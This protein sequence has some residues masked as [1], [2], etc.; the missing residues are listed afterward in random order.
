MALQISNDRDTMKV[1]DFITLED[2]RLET[3]EFDLVI[4]R[5]R[6]FMEMRKNVRFAEGSCASR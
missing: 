3:N 5:V 2:Y 4:I 1:K 6:S